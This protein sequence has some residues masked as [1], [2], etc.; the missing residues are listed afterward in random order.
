MK[1]TI[2]VRGYTQHEFN[3]I[4]SFSDKATIKKRI[5]CSDCSED[6]KNEM[7]YILNSFSEIKSI[8]DDLSVNGCWVIKELLK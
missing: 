6:R 4:R 1:K 8:E 2:S 5:D 7:N 3:L